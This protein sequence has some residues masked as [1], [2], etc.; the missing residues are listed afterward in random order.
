MIK[1]PKDFFWGSST[2]ATQSEGYNENKTVWDKLYSMDPYLFY[3]QIGPEKTTSMFKYFLDDI[4]LLKQTGHNCFRTSISWSRMFPDPFSDPD[5]SA[6][7]FYRSYF[8]ELKKNNIKVFVNLYHFDTPL[9]LEEKFGGFVSYQTVLAYQKYAKKCFELF[10]DLVDIWF[11][12]N[13]PIVSVECGYLKQYHYPMLVDPKKAVNVAFNMAL[14]SSMA[15]EEFRKLK[16]NSKIGIILNLTPAYPRSDN[17]YDIDA[18]SIAQEFA[19]NSFLDPSVKGQ[20]SE[21]LINI[22]KDND[23]LPDITNEMLD[24]IKRNTVDIL[25]VNYYQPL[26]VKAKENMP[27]PNSPFMPE[28]YYDIYDKP[29]KRI[30]P[31]RG[32][33]IYPKGIYD[34]AMNIKNNYGNIPWI[35]MENGIGV[36]D[37]NRFRVD[38]IINDEYRIEFIKEHL[39]YLHEAIQQGSN[40]KGYLVW[41]FIDCWSWLNAYK[42]RYGLV[43]LNLEDDSRIIKKSGLWFKKLS[44]NN[45][46]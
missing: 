8:S 6:V 11:T 3:N 16:L 46:F 28:K 1:F 43:E 14:A 35:I 36:Q 40:C 20:Y 41:T 10:S 12:F 38:G 32:W 7:D 2:S 22:L 21:K 27:N 9:I 37:E 24:C 34:I 5:P 4:K 13:E 31:Y 30:N 17:S 29:G 39:N 44:E 19:C 45:G 23:L 42:N 25:G 15:I 26:R 18:A 33:E